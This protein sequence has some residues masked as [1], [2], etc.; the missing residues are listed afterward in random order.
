M[1]STDHECAAAALSRMPC[2]QRAAARERRARCGGA[3]DAA[4]SL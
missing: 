3:H 2:V 4:Q 1:A